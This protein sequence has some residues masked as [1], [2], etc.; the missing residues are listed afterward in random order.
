MVSF[1]R[2]KYYLRDLVNKAYWQVHV[3]CTIWLALFAML[4]SNVSI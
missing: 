3:V 1:L 2:S 4:I